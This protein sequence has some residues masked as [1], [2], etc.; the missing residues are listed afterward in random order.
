V[1]LI[2]QRTALSNQLQQALAEYY[3]AALE[4]FTDWTLDFTW[5]FVI[6]FST[7]QH[8]VKA[9]KR[10]WE[11]F[12]HTHKL[13][14]PETAEKRLKIFAQADQFKASDGILRAKSQLAL[15]LC[16]E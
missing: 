7:P 14:R 10:R 6:E 3:P 4:A 11:K 16:G 13:W 9:G 8:L 2:E 1:T 5:D 12:L 15:C